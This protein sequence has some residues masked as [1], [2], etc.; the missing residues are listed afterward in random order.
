MRSPE[1]VRAALATAVLLIVLLPGAVLAADP[2][3]T[4][5]AG[6]DPRSAGEGPGL[7]GDPAWAIGIVV[8]I[9]VLSLVATLVY[10]RATAGRTTE[11][12][13]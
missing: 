3:P 10:V 8:A 2:S 12:P 1:R 7:V 6:G 13:A 11:P 4:A 5:A 9:A